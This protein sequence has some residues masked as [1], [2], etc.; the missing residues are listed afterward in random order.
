MSQEKKASD[1]AGSLSK[2]FKQGCMNQRGAAKADSTN[3]FNIVSNP[4]N[5]ASTSGTFSAGGPSSPHPDAF[6]PDDTLLNVDQD[7]SKIYDLEDTAKL[8]STGIFT[9]AYDDDLDTFTSPVQSVGT[10]TDFNNM[11][12]STVVS[13]IPTHRVHIYHPK[14]QILRDPQSAVQIRGMTNKSSRAHA[15]MEPKKVAQ[16]L[17]DES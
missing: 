7:D 11:E 13:P 1:A 12:S 10:E 17:K 3:S 2:E 16:A 14:D 5:A 9:S 6:I 4:I 8:K 15:F